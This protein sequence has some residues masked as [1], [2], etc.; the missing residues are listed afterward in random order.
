M[1]VLIEDY[2]YSPTELPEL[3]GIDPTELSGG[4]IKLPYVGYY[5]DGE[6]DETIF[7]LPKVFLIGGKAFGRYEPELLL[8]MTEESEQLTETDHAFLFELSAWIY[9][10]IALFCERH[11]ENEITSHRELAGV[12]GQRR[13][14]ETTLLD[15]ILALIRFGK[16][17]QSL[18][19][20][21][22]TIAHSGRHK[23]H[24]TKTI[25]TT[26]PVLQDGK[27][28]YLKCKTKEKAINYDEE[29][30]CL[31]Y[32]TLD[33]LKQ[34]YHFV[35]KRNLNYETERPHIIKRLIEDG[36]GTRRLRQIRGKYFTD[37]LVQLWHLLYAF[38]ERAEKAAQ[39]KA[40][41]ERLL[42][43]NFNSVFEDMIDSLIGEKS[44]PAGLKEQK[45]GKIID[46]IYRD[47]SL[48]GDGDIYFIGDS[49]YYKEGNSVG[50]HSRYKQF[51]YAKN[52]IQ[53]HID[54]IP[55]KAQ[56]LRYRDELTEGYNPTPNF[57]IRGTLRDD[58]SY[59]E[60]GLKPEGKGR[61]D[62]KHFE[63]RLFDRDTL[64]VLTYEINFLYVLSS[65]V[66]NRG[67]AP[68]NTLRKQFREDVIK[69]F[70]ELYCFYEL[71]PKASAEEKK[72][73]V[74]EHFKQLLGKVYQKKDGTL[75]LALK[76]EGKTVIDESIL[77]LIPD[78]D[79]CK[80]YPLS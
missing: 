77:G 36:K 65:Y 32:S 38:Y 44:L 72:A 7:I 4:Q 78:E 70:K 51:T 75:I 62:S 39:G 50:Q 64:L 19:T 6:T 2:H 52:V 48:I 49:K 31:F 79:Q 42:V 74:K 61:Y 33:Y 23:I 14:G 43:R 80:G 53:Y 3:K 25:R 58:L 68:D 8:C 1:K 76:K 18:F 16:E 55:E 73:F 71:W 67:Y 17:H 56:G 20:Y 40:H 9:Q 10:A 34:S 45:D 15:L 59:G 41:D 63:D 46:H 66:Q 69:A 37:E 21:I 35:A 27:P 26:S 11:P 28:Y 47:E 57:F 60:I 5:H 13:D 12:I 54:L 22:A 30:I 29:L 24:W